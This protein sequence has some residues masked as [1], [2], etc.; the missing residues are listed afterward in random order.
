MTES[1]FFPL[2]PASRVFRGRKSAVGGGGF[3]W[4]RNSRAFAA[5]GGEIK[6]KTLHQLD[7][8]RLARVAATAAASNPQRLAHSCANT[9]APALI[10][11]QVRVG[12]SVSR[13]ALRRPRGCSATGGA[14][15][16]PVPLYLFDFTCRD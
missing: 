7:S 15:V 6:I 12:K 1:I 4:M 16:V 11:A 3:A 5:S 10:A 14:A 8:S 9:T 13:R 2:P